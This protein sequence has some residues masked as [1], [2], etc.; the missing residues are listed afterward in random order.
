[1]KAV[2]LIVVLRAFSSGCSAL[3]GVEAVSNGVS[4]FEPPE[5]QN[6]AK[7]LMILMVV[8]L[9]LFLGLGFS[10]N[11]FHLLPTEGDTIIS[12]VA[13]ASFGYSRLGTMCYFLTTIATLSILMIAANTSFAGFPRLLAIVAKDSYAPKTFTNL[14]DRL[15]HTHGIAVLTILST[16]LVILFDAKT[17]ALIPLYAVGVFICFTLSQLGMARKVHEL[18]QPGW[19]YTACIN[20]IGALVTGIVAFIQAYSK[21][22]EGAWI[23]ILIMPILILFFY[24]VHRHYTWFDKVMSVT[25]FDDNPLANP[26]EP[27]LVLVLISSDIHRGTL[28]GLECGR[29][30][31]AERTDS[32]LRAVHIEVDPEK[33]LRLT[34]KWK[35]LVE[36]YLGQS[37]RFDVINSP[38]RWLIEPI[39]EYIDQVDLERGNGR[40]IIVLPEFETGSAITHFLHN[41][42]GKRLRN[43][44]LNRPNITVV[45]SRYFMR[46]RLWRVGRG[47]LVYL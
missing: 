38:Y 26:F 20:I 30:L 47:G 24:F 17:N 14:G 22:T 45:S 39:L 19:Q 25:K 16:I 35:Q 10:V 31:V 21:F 32:E 42:T 12:L 8:L 33:T 4:A 9:A 6:A 2:G 43:M 40:V 11:H 46:K 27:V 36:P 41:F 44:L 5:T 13:H 7:T 37:I 28:E 34:T 18:H 3:T 1:M 29:T 23:V 15:V